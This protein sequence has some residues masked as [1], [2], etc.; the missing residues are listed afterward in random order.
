MALV[1]GSFLGRY[2]IRGALGAGGMGEV[3]LAT[4]TVLGRTVALKTLPLDLL[5]DQ[6]RMHRF[7]QEARTASGLNH[8]NILT[9]YETVLEGSQPFIVTEYID[10]ATLRSH[11]NR[12]PLDL[13]KTLNL[14]LQIT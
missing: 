14:S 2:E 3:Y 8:P 7:V 10:G 1:A 9:I 4:D 13:D 11:M 5:E 12:G 6:Q